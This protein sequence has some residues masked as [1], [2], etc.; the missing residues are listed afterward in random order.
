MSADGPRRQLPIRT[1]PFPASVL[2][3]AYRN[4]F[5][6]RAITYKSPW[7]LRRS[8]RQSFLTV[9][10]LAKAAAPQ[11]RLMFFPFLL[12]FGLLLPF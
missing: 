9:C 4:R 3:V 6:R 11:C 7:P 5:V 8:C 1:C 2:L 10:S 12:A